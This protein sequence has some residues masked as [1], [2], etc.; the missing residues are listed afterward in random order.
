VREGI[1]S[2]L[3]PLPVSSNIDS[4]NLIKSRG[5]FAF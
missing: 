4:V 5:F 1:Q 2:K 3:L